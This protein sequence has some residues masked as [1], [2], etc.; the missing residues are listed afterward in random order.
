MAFHVYLRQKK[1]IPSGLKDN[2]PASA[3]IDAVRAFNQD[4]ISPPLLENL[5]LDW[6]CS[7]LTSSCWNSEAISLLSLDFY[8]NLKGGA[9]RDVI[10][11]T[12]TMSLQAICKLCEQK[13]V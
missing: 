12:Q 13:L 4:G 6:H 7:P 1:I 10:F 8:N 11:D 2:L 9:Y 5:A 3:L